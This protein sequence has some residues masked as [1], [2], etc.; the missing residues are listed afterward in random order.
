MVQSIFLFFK[1]FFETSVVSIYMLNNINFVIQKYNL[2]L[3]YHF[4][5]FT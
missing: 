5:S 1:I 3:V 2:C 4:I